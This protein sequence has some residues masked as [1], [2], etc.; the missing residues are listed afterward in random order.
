MRHLRIAGV[1]LGGSGYPNATETI[2]LLK[3]SKGW[4]VQDQARW[5][6]PETRLWR[7]AGGPWPKRIWSMTWLASSGCAQALAI[8]IAARKDEYVY[9]PYPAPLTLWWLSF[10]PRKWRARCIADAYISVW[11][12]MFR[13]RATGNTHSL[14]SRAVK[15]FERRSLHAASVI[16]VDTEANRQQFVEDFGLNQEQIRSIPLAIDETPFVRPGKAPPVSNRIRVLFVGTLA[17]LHGIE[18]ILAAMAHLANEPGIEFRLV[19]DGQQSALVEDFLRSTNPSNF[20][21]T[22]DWLSLAEIASEIEQA[23]ICLGV[24]GGDGKA[25]RVLPFKLYYAFAAGKATITQSGLSL[26]YG[27]QPPPAILVPG[28]SIEERASSLA[29]EIRSLA[30][31]PEKRKSMADATRNYF[32]EKLSGTAILAS[33]DMIVDKE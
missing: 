33:W 12:S 13:D 29:S 32:R 22:R 26:P 14:L 28:I 17:P 10:F 18:T 25:S 5:L 16:L 6:P 30:K 23:D 7:L 31:D 21:W 27:I 11:D 24:F 3:E 9:L 2:R 15:R 1:A 20:T 19:G 4:I 8:V